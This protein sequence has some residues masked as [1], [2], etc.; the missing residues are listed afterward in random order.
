[1]VGS[2]VLIF[3]G[4]LL[5][6]F[7]PPFGKMVAEEARKYGQLRAAHARIITHSEEIAFYGY[8]ETNYL[9]SV[10]FHV[11]AQRVQSLS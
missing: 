6:S 5:K 11:Y 2:S 4:Y 3:T 9:K 1:M 8:V 10:V 7:T